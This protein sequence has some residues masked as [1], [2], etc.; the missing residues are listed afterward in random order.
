MRQA[1]RHFD[2]VVDLG[3]EPRERGCRSAYP[4]VLLEKLHLCVAQGI[5]TDRYCRAPVQTIRIPVNTPG[6]PLEE[7]LDLDLNSV[8]DKIGGYHQS[9]H[10]PK[11]DRVAAQHGQEGGCCV[12]QF[13]WVTCDG[14]Q[15]REIG[16]SSDV[17]ILGK[18]CGQVEAYKR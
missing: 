8:D 11:E 18:C 14:N 16:S 1:D 15:R 2:A 9:R 7:V 4:L 12:Y 17:D 10:R 6:A 5:W 13:P 3:D